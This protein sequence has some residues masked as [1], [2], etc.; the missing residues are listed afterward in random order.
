MSEDAPAALN[1]LPCGWLRLDAH[2]TVV[3]VNY[4]LCHMLGTEASKL[5]GRPF[6]MLTAC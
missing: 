1:R 3:A 5:Q 2:G 4:A 6:D